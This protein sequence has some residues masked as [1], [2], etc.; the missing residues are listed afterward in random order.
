MAVSI[1]VNADTRSARQDLSKLENSVRS[2]ETT[3]KKVSRSLT[4][5][6]TGIA[7]AFAG[8]VTIRSINTATDGLIG[9]ENR[10]ALVT[11]RTEQLGKSL[12]NLY[13]IARNS[14]SSIDNAGETFNRFG[15][16]LRDA[17]V[18]VADIEKATDSVQKAVALSGGNAASA[19][20]AIFQLGQ[21]LASGTLRGQELNSVLEQAPR[22]ALAIADNMNV[23]VGELRALAA[24]GKVTTDVVFNALLDQSEK[25][26]SEFGLLEQ[27]SAQ[28]F[29][30][31]NDSL[32]R[33]TGNISRTIGIT[34]IFTNSFNKLTDAIINS[35][36]AF[37]LGIYSSIANFRD[38][39]LNLQIIFGGI[40]NVATAFTG[41]VANAIRALIAPARDAADKI[42]VSFISPLLGVERQYRILGLNIKSVFDNF[43]QIGSRGAVRRLFVATSA[44]EAREALDDLAD[45]I[46]MAGRRWYNFGAQLKNVFN[47]LAIGT[48]KVL[49]NLG[50]IDQRLL[51]FRSTSMEDF[52]FILELT[53]DLLKEVYEN[54]LTLKVIRVAAL[55][56]IKFRQLVVQTLNATISDIK[57]LYKTLKNITDKFLDSLFE[58]TNAKKPQSE[59]TNSLNKL[60]DNIAIIYRNIK[61]TTDKFFN[62][63]F[64][65]AETN[66]NKTEKLIVNSL[67]S[68]KNAFADVYDKVIG[69]SWW[70][71]TMEETYYLSEKYLGITENR[72]LGFRDT[73]VKAYENLYDKVSAISSKLFSDFSINKDIKINIDVKKEAETALQDPFNYIKTKIKEIFVAIGK[74]ISAAFSDLY[75]QL[76]DVAPF[77]TGIIAAI[78]GTKL[79]GLLSTSLAASFSSLIRGGVLAAIGI[80]LVDAFGDALLDSG[81]LVDFAKGL[82]SAAG[83]FVDLII[84]NIPQIISAFTQVVSGFGQGIA[85]SLTGIPGLIA[86]LITS[87]PLGKIAFGAISAALVSYFTGFGPTK[88]VD[89][90]IKDRQKS[91]DKSAKAMTKA[92]KKSGQNLLS[93]APQISFIESVLIGRGG[94]R[95]TLGKLAGIIGIADIALTS[96]FGDTRMTDAILAGGIIAELM[97]GGKGVTFITGKIASAFFSINSYFTNFTK[98]AKTQSLSTSIL[99]LGRDIQVGFRN[100]MYKAG[101]FVSKLFYNSNLQATSFATTSK[102]SAATSSAA[103]S[104]AAVKSQTAWS[105]AFRFMNRRTIAFGVATTAA[106]AMFTGTAD[107]AAAGIEETTQSLFSKIA[108]FAT[109]VILGPIGIIGSIFLGTKKGAAVGSFILGI[110]NSLAGKI[111]GLVLRVATKIPFVKNGL[112]GLAFL[113][114]GSIAAGI[115]VGLKVAGAALLSFIA[116]TT[117]VVTG[118]AAVAG[119]V[120]VA[121]FGEGDTIGEKFKNATN[122]VLKFFGYASIEASKLKKSLDK[123]L[124]GFDKIG[125]IDVNFKGTIGGFNFENVSEKN[126]KR[127]EKVALKTNRIL[128]SA[129]ATFEREGKVGAAET[130][131]VKRAVDLARKEIVDAN[132]DPQAGEAGSLGES[133][134]AGDRLLVQGILNFNKLLT[135]QNVSL[136]NPLAVFKSAQ[137]ELALSLNIDKELVTN[138]VVD[139]FEILAN[140]ATVTPSATFLALNDLI[141]NDAIKKALSASEV[142]KELLEIFDNLANL[143]TGLKAQNISDENFKSVLDG[144]AKFQ[145]ELFDAEKNTL[146]VIRDRDYGGGSTSSARDLIA[147]LEQANQESSDEV[148]RQ[149][150]SVAESNFLDAAS[151]LQD[152]LGD[153]F[154]LDSADENIVKILGTKTLNQ[155]TDAIEQQLNNVAEDF[156]K[157]D[158]DNLTPTEIR[159]KVITDLERAASN[160]A[161]GIMK[162][163]GLFTPS[164]KVTT[165]AQN[166]LDSINERLQDLQLD[167]LLLRPT[168]VLNKDVLDVSGKQENTVNQKIINSLNIIDSLNKEIN[169]SKDLSI[170]KQNKLITARAKEQLLLDNLIK[171]ENAAA[172]AIVKPIEALEGALDKV[173]DSIS[174]DEA[175]G[176]DKELISQ[177]LDLSK[178]LDIIALK[179]QKIKLLGE[180]GGFS[181]AALEFIL[182]ELE[183]DQILTQAALDRIL[184]NKNAPDTTDTTDDTKTLTVFEQFVEN[185]NNSGF[186]FELSQAAKLSKEAILSLEEPLKRIKIAQ[187]KIVN[188][189]LTDVSGRRQA[190]NVIKEEREKIFESLN[191]GTLEQKAIGFAA[192]GIDPS[193]VEERELAQKIA[194][195]IVNLEDKLINTSSKNLALR[196]SINL[197]LDLSR[198]LLE[199]ITTKAEAATDRMRS[200]F[201]S[202]FK[203]LL[204]GEATVQQFFDKF[205][206]S[207]SNQII[208]T[209]VDSFTQAF[210]KAANLNQ[211]FDKMFAGLGLFGAQVGTGQED[212]T[213]ANVS[214]NADKIAEQTNTLAEGINQGLRDG[215]D[216]TWMETL[217]SGAGNYISALGEGLMGMLNG[218]LGGVNGAGGSSFS[219]VFSL[220]GNFGSSIGTFASGFASSV[221]NMFS[222]FGGL[223]MNDGGIVPHTPYSRAGIDSVPAMLTPG[224][225]IVPANKVQA[226]EN[227]NSNQQSVVNLSITGDVSRQTRQEIVKMLPQISAGVNATN[228]ENNFKYRR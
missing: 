192:I 83:T 207:L 219:N 211:M 155:L 206:D 97:F 15:I 191:N 48:E 218:V 197:E 27:T 66:Q 141:E 9:L 6:A 210:F 139:L 179:L 63:L 116:T 43:A 28:S 35:G 140:A 39:L 158:K 125:D 67:N 198:Q 50:I 131:R 152:I 37:E 69:N 59:I 126:A 64:D 172:L 226:F 133:S 144:I 153:A 85:D 160:V 188:L 120:G 199:E 213:Q 223:F 189:G 7:T 193:L 137:K 105:K 87:L 12:D 194:L 130:R 72:I 1:R 184:A 56:F 8:T 101:V 17:G 46:D 149:I 166:A 124:G 110:F 20:A 54:I 41:R 217:F 118:A 201:A 103:Y 24:E 167:A 123:T 80:T 165:E 215:V 88:L 148:Q 134:S 55:A 136:D 61:K 52:N 186:S 177:S 128:T 32:K 150:R 185:L 71:D 68:I 115:G 89:G 154:S 19:S 135:N 216:S 45:A 74:P 181:G 106:L 162:Q 132:T 102:I 146:K 214:V 113:G 26:N 117:A 183:R 62:S 147:I 204:K 109:N 157:L 60:K 121:L 161:E 142:G 75:K 212:P 18:A 159:K 77:L 16:A 228:K 187:D 53:S 205:L 96:L 94:G 208:D 25:L 31:F 13:K 176:I 195:N 114:K 2:I 65:K 129:Q 91:F 108:T 169:N 174:F 175:L 209:V 21:G 100:S 171:T 127:L 202:S 220:L 84:S 82:G 90:F 111:G 81:F 227:R 99:D 4:R 170:K 22:I 78:F 225:L 200:A 33:V 178:N 168:K 112:I 95:R 3:G 11:G 79:V 163:T 138:E 86:Q 92:A 57:K 224:E 203:E 93:A 222:S 122:S 107:A 196:K 221:G 104:A 40:A 190:L 156:K 5:L 98:I 58:R 42:Y 38:R 34:S 164:G 145:A 143:S 180:S 70:T 151:K 30:V 51:R 173:D 47:P 73:I 119:L 182:Q 36:G 23:A 76:G 10:I 14:R 44:E 49:I 29:I